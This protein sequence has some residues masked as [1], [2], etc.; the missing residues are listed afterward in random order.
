MTLPAVL[1]VAGLSGHGARAGV[2]GALASSTARAAVTFGI[3]GAVPSGI[4]ATAITTAERALGLFTVFK[5]KLIAALSVAFA[6]AALGAGALG[7]QSLSAENPKIDSIQELN[8]EAPNKTQAIAAQKKATALPAEDDKLPQGAVARFG[9]NRLK[10]IGNIMNLA[11]SPDGTKLASWSDETYIT[12]AL[13]IWNSKSGELLR[14][15]DIPGAEVLGLEWMQDG[16]IIG[17]IDTGHGEPLVWDFNQ[18]TLVPTVEP[19]RKMGFRSVLRVP[20]GPAETCYALSP[21]GQTL[22]VG[23]SEK[24]SSSGEIVLRQLKT[25]VGTRG[26]FTQRQLSLQPGVPELLFYTPDGKRVVAFNKPEKI[27]EKQKAAKQLIVVWEVAKGKEICRFT[28]QCPA[29]YGANRPPVA[30]SNRELAIGLDDG[31]TSLW[32]LASGTQRRIATAHSGRK[33]SGKYGTLAIAF[34]PDGKSFVTG[35]GDGLVK[36]WETV[37]GKHVRTLPRNYS[38]VEALTEAPDNRTIA[39]GYY[40]VNLR[41]TGRPCEA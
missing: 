32:D 16:R 41:L 19:L 11:Y 30:V 36:V 2:P 4:S 34:F 8:S 7:F 18:E 29:D 24:D 13:C 23:L 10:P 27:N 40:P 37:S 26:L 1:L 5:L 38:G 35:G 25:G 15:T 22:A 39:A 28:A 20:P 33:P 9:N 21:D 17:L 31:G 6:L 3:R 14:R 12:S